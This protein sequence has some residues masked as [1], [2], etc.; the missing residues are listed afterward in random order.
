MTPAFTIGIEEEY[1]TLD[2]DSYDL[3]SH[4][5][6]QIMAE[7]KRQL[8]E[9]VK[10]EMHQAVVEVGTGVCRSMREARADLVN[11]RRSTSRICG[12]A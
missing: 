6:T 9:K 2:P 1:Q 7:G 10:A 11:L 4:I 8:A 12:G 3:R 5:N